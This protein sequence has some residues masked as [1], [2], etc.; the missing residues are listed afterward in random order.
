M[1]S[2]HLFLK[3]WQI[4][5]QQKGALVFTGGETGAMDGT[6]QSAWPPWKTGMFRLD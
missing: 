2:C 4:Y 3:S 6:N 5:L 1:V